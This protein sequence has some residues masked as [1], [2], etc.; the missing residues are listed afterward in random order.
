MIKNWDIISQA[1]SASGHRAFTLV[2]DGNETD[3]RLIAKKLEGYVQEPVP[4]K[5]PFTYAFALPANLD[6]NTLEKIRTAVREGFFVA[7]RE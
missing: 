2:I 3:A 6:E 1:T 5:P 7:Y 4:A